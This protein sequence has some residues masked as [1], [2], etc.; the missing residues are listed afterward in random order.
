MPSRGA[1]ARGCDTFPGGPTC[2]ESRHSLT[3]TKAARPDHQAPMKIP[4]K[5]LWCRADGAPVRYQM[6]PA[7]K[8]WA[9]IFRLAARDWSVAKGCL[10]SDPLKNA[11]LHVRS[12]TVRSNGITLRKGFRIGPGRVAIC[13]APEGARISC[14]LYPALKGWAKLFR[15][16]ARD[17]GIAKGRRSGSGRIAV[18]L[19]ARPCKFGRVREE[20]IGGNWYT[21]RASTLG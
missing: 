4:R 20:A 13:V 15:L 2:A 1:A 6:H 12:E 3:L 7:L 19:S 8:G 17:W 14:H 10:S 16:A 11:D 21:F 18:L 9:K 5:P